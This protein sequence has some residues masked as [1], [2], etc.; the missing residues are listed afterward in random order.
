MARSWHE[1]GV[2]LLWLTVISICGIGLIDVLSANQPS[3]KFASEAGDVKTVDKREELPSKEQPEATATRQLLDQLKEQ[4]AGK[5]RFTDDWCRTLKDIADLG[6][7]AVPELIQELDSTDDDMMLGCLGFVLRAIGDKRAIPSLIRAIPKTLLPPGSDMGLRADDPELLKFAQEND[8]RP[9]NHANEYGFGRPVREICGALHKLTGKEFEE[10]ELFVV[11]FVGSASQQQRK[12]VC[13]QRLAETWAEWWEQK[14]MDYLQDQEYSKVHLPQR[15][16]EGPILPP[17]ADS[18]FKT[19]NGRSSNWI[20]ESYQNPSAKLV[21]YDFDVGRA[22]ALPEKWRNAID[23]ESHL[24]EI[25]FWAT[26]EGFDLMG[27]EFETADGRKIFAL[28]SIGLRAWELGKERWK[29]NFADVTLKDLQA[30]GRLTE[31]LLLHY[32]KAAQS[33]AP[34]ETATFL[35][36]TRHGTPG[37]LYV[38]IEVQDDSLKPGGKAMGDSELKPVAFYKGRRFGF[39]FLEE[40]TP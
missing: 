36:I 6:S 9:T 28:R 8:I 15:E 25:V 35:F 16:D 21:F 12:R 7:D 40:I 30:E 29:S 33:V 37:L 31:T 13:F 22:A 32:D 18:H 17:S 20:L 38:G 27:T 34:L 11:F 1:N 4:N 10:K 5:A 39:T 2:T 26:R 24:D 23:I 3:D 19:G 14:W